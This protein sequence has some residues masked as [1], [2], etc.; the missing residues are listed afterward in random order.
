MIFGSF[1]YYHTLPHHLTFG[2]SDC[3]CSQPLD[4]IKI[5]LF[6]CAHGGERTII[7]DVVWDVF[8]FQRMQ[9][10]MFYLSKPMFFCCLP[11]NFRV[12]RSTLWFQWMVFGCWLTSSLLTPFKY[13]WFCGFFYCTR[14]PWWSRLKLRM[15]FIAI[16]TQQKCINQDSK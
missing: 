7:Y 11:F 4:P 9:D 14:L 15:A 3:I 5:H 8:V 10:F 13:I 12:D 6:S 1:D 2:L 16:N